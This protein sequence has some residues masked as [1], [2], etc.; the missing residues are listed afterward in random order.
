MIRRFA[1]GLIMA[2]ALGGAAPAAPVPA[3]YVYTG[4]IDLGPAGFWDYSN[5]DAA[6]GRLY[7]GHVDRVDVVDVATRKLVGSVGPLNEAHGAAIAVALGRGFATSGGD[8]LLKVF[9]LADL[10]IIKEIPVGKDADAVIFDPRTGQVIVTVGDGKQMVIVDAASGGLT[11]TIDLPGA[12]EYPAVDGRGKAFVN[13]ASTSQLA[14]IDIASGK[15]EAVWDLPGCKNPHGLAYD[16]RTHR[17]FSGCS[18]KVLVVVDPESGKLIASLPTGGFT[19]GV[20]VDEARGRVFSP[21]G[22]GTLTVIGEGPGDRYAVL[23]TIPTFL[24]GRSMAVDPR[25]GE[26]FVTHG[27]TVIK[28]GMGNAL[29]LRFGWDGAK[30]A[31]FAPND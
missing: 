13:L 23:R 2:L 31:T 21:N 30:V 19:D 7:I 8:G 17:L 11:H 15:I 3:D 22:D 26:L 20:A 25:S 5:Y 29:E 6:T 18:N 24:G 28:G 10:K 4:D 16:H 9:G 12:P 1:A 27:D 14:R